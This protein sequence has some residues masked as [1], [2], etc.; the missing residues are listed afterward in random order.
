MFIPS[1][2][3]DNESQVESVG[4][5]DE[6]VRVGSRP[7]RLLQDTVILLICVLQNLP[8]ITLNWK[9]C[10]RPDSL[11]PLPM[12][13]DYICSFIKKM[14]KLKLIVFSHTMKT[15]KTYI[16]W[17]E[18]WKSYFTLDRVFSKW[19]IGGDIVTPFPVQ[20]REII[21]PRWILERFPLPGSDL[22]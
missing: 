20:Q 6:V 14:W 19:V 9:R 13:N 7:A 3:H 8:K 11:L 15:P 18:T 10:T 16:Y 17:S 22:Y 2:L 4:K 12:F 5:I 1:V 21:T